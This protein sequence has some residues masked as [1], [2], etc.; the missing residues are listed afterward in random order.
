MINLPIPLAT[1]PWTGLGRK[2]ESLC[3]KALYEYQLLEGID[4]LAIAL[5]GGKDSLS[6]LFLLKAIL[7][8]GFPPIQLHAIHIGGAFSCGAGISSSFLKG[9]CEKLDVPLTIVNVDQDINTLQCYSCSRNRRKILFEIAKSVQATTIAFGHHRD[10]SVETLFMNLM[11]KAEFAAM[12]P[13]VPMYDYGVTI[14][15]PLIYVPEESLIQFAKFYEFSRVVCQCPVGQKSMRK[16]VK[17]ILKDIQEKF[18]N[19]T[20]NLATVSRTY[21][22]QKALKK[23]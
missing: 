4:K 17:N 10:D 3:R 11:H 15:R 7:G 21:G 9:I 12:L 13:K 20:D 16:T 19:A 18:P 1:P 6:L 8:K 5:S 23:P 22:S 2:L 14:I